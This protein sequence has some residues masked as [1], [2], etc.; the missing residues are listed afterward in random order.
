MTSSSAGNG[1]DDSEDQWRGSG[2]VAVL[3]PD[4]FFGMRIRASLRQLGYVVAIVKDGEA[5]TNLL[6]DNA[7]PTVL[8]LVDFNTPVDWTKLQQA[9]ATGI[10]VVAFG[11]HTDVEGFRAAKAAGAARVVSN[12]EFSRSLPALAKRHALPAAT[13]C[14]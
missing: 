2:R 6:I 1:A 13:D 11:P 9:L 3:S 8:G 10:P 14:N 7:A 12:G 5:F 4:L